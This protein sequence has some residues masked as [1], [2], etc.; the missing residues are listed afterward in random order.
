VASMTLSHGTVPPLGIYSLLASVSQPIF[1]GGALKGK[2]KQSQARYQELLVG[3]YRQAVLSSF[4]DVEN[5]LAAL[6]AARAEKS[7][8]E[9]AAALAQQSA[10]MALGSLQGG[11]GTEL[12]VLQTQSTVLTAQDALVQA[13]LAYADALLSLIK[14][15]GGGW[16]A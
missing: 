8:D 5:A 10:G 14:A 1:H 9:R 2:L 16:K 6:R 15:L 12:D 13:R 3:A 7:S 4:G 11:T